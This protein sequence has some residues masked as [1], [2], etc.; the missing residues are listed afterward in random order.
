MSLVGVASR[1]TRLGPLAGCECGGV[2]WVWLPALSHCGPLVAVVVGLVACSGGVLRGCSSPLWFVRACRLLLWSGWLRVPSAC[3]SRGCYSP[4]C[5]PGC[6]ALFSCRRPLLRG[7]PVVGGLP[8]L[9]RG[10][11]DGSSRV[12]FLL[13]WWC[14]YGRCGA[15]QLPGHFAGLCLAGFLALGPLGVARGLA[16]TGGC[17]PS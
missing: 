15:P 4:V 17:P 7:G 16:W 5:L 10:T 12:V 11:S 13:A 8:L 14:P 3:G 1:P 2:L 9:W 6:V